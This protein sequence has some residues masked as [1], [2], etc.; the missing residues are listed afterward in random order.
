MADTSHILAVNHSAASGHP[1]DNAGAEEPF[2]AVARLILY[3]EC[4]D[5]EAGMRMWATGLP[6]AR[7]IEAIVG[8]QD[9]WIVVRELTGVDHVNGRVTICDEAR[10]GR[11]SVIDRESPRVAAGFMTQ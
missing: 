8:E 4:D 3:R 6:P 10:T 1:P 2:V 9:E 5:L 11:R 7:Q